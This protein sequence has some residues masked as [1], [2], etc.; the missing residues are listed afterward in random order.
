MLLGIVSRSFLSP[1]AAWWRSSITC[2]SLVA[3]V[4]IPSPL[5]LLCAGAA[6]LEVEGSTLGEVLRAVDEHCP[7]FL[8]RT[9][10][11]G[12]IRPELSIALN[13]HAFHY[14][15]TEPIAKD[16]E[17]TIVPAIGGG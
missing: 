13:G 2:S 8:D 1:P 3:T 6:F 12:R 5:R 17:L 14:G 16:D 4:L 11:G 9:V 15:L 7:G 10:E